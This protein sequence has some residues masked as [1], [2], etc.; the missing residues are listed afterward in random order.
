MVGDNANDVAVARALGVPVILRADGYTRVPAADLGA[1]A[2][3]GH[4]TELPNA[5]ARFS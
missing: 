2:I 5:L 4:F 3:I 1:D